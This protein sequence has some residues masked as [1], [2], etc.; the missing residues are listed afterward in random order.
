MFHLGSRISRILRSPRYASVCR[1]RRSNQP[2][3]TES[4]LW[5][6][7]A[8]IT[9]GG[10]ITERDRLA[11]APSAELWDTT[12]S[13]SCDAEWIERRCARRSETRPV[14]RSESGPLEGGSFYALL[15]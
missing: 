7:E 15:I 2:V 8:S 6:A 12:A 5:R 1:S 9:A 4:T 11:W 13:R 14:G 10:Y 3:R